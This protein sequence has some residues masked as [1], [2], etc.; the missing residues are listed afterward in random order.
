M[1]KIYYFILAAAI[2]IAGCEK[3]D[4]N[5]GGSGTNPGDG[6]VTYPTPEKNATYTIEVTQGIDGETWSEGDAI[7]LYTSDTKINNSKLVV[8]NPG[9]AAGTFTTAPVTLPAGPNKFIAYYPY[10]MD[11]FMMQGKIA[12]MMIDE[13]QRVTPGQIPSLW[14][15]ASFTGIPV[16]DEKFAGTLTPIAGIAKISVASSVLE[17]YALKSISLSDVSGSKSLGGVY[18]LTLATGELSA[19]NEFASVKAVVAN[20]NLS[21]TVTDIYVQ[22]YPTSYS[23]LYLNIELEKEG[24]TLN[25][26]KKIVDVNLTPGAIVTLD[27]TGLTENTLE[28]DYYVADDTRLFPDGGYAYGQ[29]NTF[30]IQCKSGK[31]YNGATYNPDPNIPGTVTIDIRGRGNFSKLVD[32]KGATFE[33][34]KTKSGAI[35]TPT[36]EKYKSSGIKPDQ[37]TFSYDGNYTVT[38]TANDGAYAGAPILLMK[39]GGKVLW[40]WTFWNIAADGTRF[41][42]M[43]VSGTDNDN[44][45]CTY[46][47]A[48]MDIGQATTKYSTWTANQSSEAKPDVAFRTIC[49]YQH[50]RHIPTFW[51]SYWSY[52]T[53]DASG[54]VPLIL[55]PLTLDE[56]I[57]NPVGQ[58]LNPAGTADLA[59]WCLDTQ[60]RIWGGSEH[61]KR[62]VSIKTCFDPCPEG[63]RVPP[64]SLADIMAKKGLTDVSSVN[65]AQHVTINGVSGITFLN[66][67]YVNGKINPDN[68]RLASMGG[69]DSG[70]ADGCKYGMFWTSMCGAKQGYAL[71]YSNSFADVGDRS[72]S[73]NRTLS[74][75]VRCIKDVNPVDDYQ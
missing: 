57:S 47:V 4:K 68:N 3:A 41:G 30:F 9:S 43:T 39:K 16:Q 63:W 62:D 15:Y 22:L 70:T 64:P 18:A 5:D 10:S 66:Q 58:I 27:A 65:G 75:P 71:L 24:E 35:Y 26:I 1:K 42:S 12:G 23:G 69:G 45:N 53:A 59:S 60:Q 8:K 55:K 31:T 40:A 56:A 61:N 25:L 28:A 51:T 49:Y 6:G 74:A 20:C 36:T 32:P 46:N 2:I 50:G 67:G 48:T 17:G 54:N 19:M 34:F 44:K 21:S 13:S 29:A 73:F 33:W 52:W 11:V 14:S 7:G 38:V 37:F 72:G